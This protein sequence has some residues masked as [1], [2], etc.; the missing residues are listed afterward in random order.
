MAMFIFAKAI[1]RG[2]PIKLFD[3][4]HMRRDM[5][6]VDDVAEA[7][8]RIIATVPAETAGAAGRHSRSGWQYG[9]HGADYN[10]GNN[11]TVEIRRIVELL[12]LELGRKAKIEL[13]PNAAG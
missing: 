2:Q 5:P 4:G 7:L 13:M 10:I 6:F 1:T 3:Q 11:Q 9:L 12:E 8:E